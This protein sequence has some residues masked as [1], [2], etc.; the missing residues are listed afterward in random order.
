MKSC[1]LPCLIL[2]LA[3]PWAASAQPAKPA[4]EARPPAKLD[5]LT[6][7]PEIRGKID[8]FFTILKQRKVEEAYRRL[9][10]GSVLAADNPELVKKLEES[11]AQVLDL[12]GRIDGTEILRIRTAG[13]TLREVTYLLNGEKRP[14]RW[15]FY[16]YL[17]AGRWQVLD[18]NVATEASGF[19]DDEKK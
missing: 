5:A 1:R 13:K 11:T 17:A 18:T 3:L 9:L 12:T 16:F 2:A 10:D 14:L 6:L 8:G 7:E 19:F 4:T 15:K